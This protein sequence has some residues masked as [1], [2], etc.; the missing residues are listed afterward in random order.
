MT[1]SLLGHDSLNS[2]QAKSMKFFATFALWL[3]ANMVVTTILTGMLL[4]P[5]LNLGEA[6]STVALGTLIGAIPLV[7]V[8][9]M[10]QRTGLPTMVLS[11][12]A[13]GNLGAK[14]ISLINVCMLVGWSWI[15]A[16]LAAMS[17]NFAI[18]ATFGYSNLPLMIVI[19]ESIVV[20]VVLRGHLGIERVERWAAVMMLGLSL[21][22]FYAL[23]NHYDLGSLLEL[24]KRVDGITIGIAFDIVVATAFS[25]ISSSADYNRNCNSPRTAVCATYLG[26]FTATLL[27][28]TLGAAVS[29]LS[30][31]NDMPQTYDPTQLL[32]QFGFG[33][34][35][36]L[37]IFLSVMTTNIMAVYSATLSAMNLAPEMKF[38]K[39]ALV[40]G[41]VS[42]FGALIPGILDQFQNFLIIIG[43]LFIPAFAVMICDYYLIDSS[44]YNADLLKQK[45]QT[46]LPTARYAFA[47]YLIGAGLST[48]WTLFSPLSFGSSLPVFLITGALYW[49]SVKL[50]VLRGSQQGTQQPLEG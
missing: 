16:L 38:W 42:V 2:T 30:L 44:S 19:C 49:F 48:Y 13:Y 46:G 4:V 22:V 14:F 1:G 50:L 8:G 36:A 32:S 11:R 24:P 5:D 21:A 35:A 3:G 28:M 33:L 6:L 23:N 41:L 34:P 10:G 18:E 31:L 25:W 17:L 37:V 26:Y 12:R 40:I 45:H 47:A 27:A 20:L 43:G 9:L 39:P 29:G 15:Q 7:L